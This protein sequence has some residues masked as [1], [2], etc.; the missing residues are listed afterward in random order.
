MS[1]FY[2]LMIGIKKLLSLGINVKVK[3]KNC[4]IKVLSNFLDVYFLNT[5]SCSI[6]KK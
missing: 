4:N 1:I 3:K 6:K 5:Y 2:Q